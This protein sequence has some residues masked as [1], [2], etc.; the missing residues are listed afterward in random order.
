VRHLITLIVSTLLGLVMVPSSQAQE[1]SAAA[2][3]DA[4]DQAINPFRK[5]YLTVEITR[6]FPAGYTERT[7]V[8]G[9]AEPAFTYIHDLD[10]HWLMGLGVQ[11]KVLAQRDQD[12]LPRASQWLALL[13][14]SHEVLYALRLSH[15]IYF[16]AGPKLLYMVPAK[17]GKL[18]LQRDTNYEMEIGAALTTQFAYLIDDR[19]M[20]SLRLDR[21]RGTKTQRLNGTEVALGVSWATR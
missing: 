15:P 6:N 1:S 8:P 21:W 12:D 17:S 11:F 10:R 7:M 2:S 5:T 16:L 18:P 13:T 9:T 14:L 20:L 4:F 19:H 3:M